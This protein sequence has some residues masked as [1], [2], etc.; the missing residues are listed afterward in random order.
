MSNVECSEPFITEELL[1]LDTRLTKDRL[2]A[3]N[4]RPNAPEKPLSEFT[5]NFENLSNE[6]D[7]ELDR[8]VIHFQTEHY[9]EYASQSSGDNYR[10]IHRADIKIRGAKDA[11]ITYNIDAK[12]TFSF[13]TGAG[14][15]A[16]LVRQNQPVHN[17]LLKNT[18]IQAMKG[19]KS[20][21]VFRGILT[22]GTY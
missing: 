7:Q 21:L 8:G 13:L 10:E 16:F 19:S 17:C 11:P 15:K 4:N 14:L 20:E 3:F 2:T 18:C 22:T 9:F 5:P 1:I 6:G 12:I